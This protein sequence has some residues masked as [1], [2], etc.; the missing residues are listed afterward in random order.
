MFFGSVLK[1]I[2]CTPNKNFDEEAY[3]R[4]VLEPARRIRAL[5]EQVGEGHLP[6]EQAHEVMA[7]LLTIFQTKRVEM[8]ERTDRIMEILNRNDLHELFPELLPLSRS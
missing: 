4:G 5:S 8:D 6:D 7:L 2:A 1:A 3:A